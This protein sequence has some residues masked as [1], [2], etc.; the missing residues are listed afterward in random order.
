MRD[1]QGDYDAMASLTWL[2]TG[3]VTGA[4]WWAGWNPF[5]GALAG[6]LGCSAVSCTI[7]H[8]ADREEEQA[9]GHRPG[10]PTEADPWYEEIAGDAGEQ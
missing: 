6:F 3:L 9:R 5:V 10:K 8:F 1:R 2:L 7:L 4:F